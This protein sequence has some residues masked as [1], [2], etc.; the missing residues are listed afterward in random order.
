VDLHPDYL[1]SRYRV[2][3]LRAIA[4]HN[5][6][7]VRSR[8]K[9]DYIRALSEGLFQDQT[10]AA[11]L[12]KLDSVAGQLLRR[13]ALAGGQVPAEWISSRLKEE[14]ILSPPF[15]EGLQRQPHSLEEALTPLVFSGLVFM[16]DRVPRASGS[17]LLTA[18][19][20]LVIPSP[21]MEHLPVEPLV[22]PRSTEEPAAILPGSIGRAQRVFYLCWNYVRHHPFRPTSSGLPPESHLRDIR[23]E[24]TLQDPSDE[25]ET[26]HISFL[27]YMLE[28]LGVLEDE[29][30][31]LRAAQGAENFF[32]QDP[33]MRA[34]SMLRAWVESARW[35]SLREDFWDQ[36]APR[37]GAL[38][39]LSG[40]P[41]QAWVTVRDWCWCARWNHSSFFL[42]PEQDLLRA[43]VESLIRHDLALYDFLRATLRG[44][45]RWLGLVS[46]GG[47]AMD[48][49]QLTPQ[50]SSVLAHT[51]V[52][53]EGAGD[54][55]VQPD[56]HILALPPVRDGDL[57]FLDEFGHRVKADRAFEY[58]L[59]RSSVYAAQQSGREV[60]EIVHF[61]ESRTRSPLPQN[62]ARSLQD[63]E[64]QYHRIAFHPSAA[65]CQV[66]EPEVLDGLL[67][68]PSIARWVL[69]R[70]TPTEAILRDAGRFL[71]AVRESGHS[72]ILVSPD[73]DIGDPIIVQADGHHW[74]RGVVH[75]DPADRDS[76]LGPPTADMEKGDIP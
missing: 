21:V 62:V 56:F 4:R 28:E 35:S 76:A 32:S 70:P 22:P 13:L 69:Q 12:A 67:Q 53:E 73:G 65:V 34:R 14:G 19:D 51:E 20:G 7:E 61:L 54:L 72:S 43:D 26:A 64:R 71:S 27:L 75:P 2:A 11:S 47:S 39:S 30:G 8:R 66:M 48:L 37:Q 23:R 17:A 29:G 59:T 63:W 45:L 60:K 24:L 57:A 46:L 9:S 10:I 25:H 40:L 74:A 50:A 58:Q 52:G 6:I 42:P 3:T 44:P 41:D 36:E 18:R 1:L 31:C 49:L 68:E 33:V 15:D 55:I 38:V 16:V 5:H